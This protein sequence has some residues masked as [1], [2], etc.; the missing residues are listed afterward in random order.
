[1]KKRIGMV[2]FMML[3]S[4]CGVS[5]LIAGEEREEEG[6]RLE[7]TTRKAFLAGLDI[8]TG[9]LDLPDGRGFAALM[10]GARVGRGLS[11]SIVLLLENTT[12]LGMVS[13]VPTL[14]SALV[15]LQI[16]VADPLYLKP[17]AGMAWQLEEG[18]ATS[19]AGFA[20]GFATG[21]ELRTGKHFAIS[22]EVRLGYARVKGSNA[23]SIGS[24]LDMKF[25]F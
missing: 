15:S 2:L 7:E 8:G 9:E 21:Y 14:I 18:T 11:E 5:S 20:F 6:K 16:F 23:I 13:S 22:P 1:M 3:L 4:L 12:A 19:K 10:T 24:T 25:Y 17:G